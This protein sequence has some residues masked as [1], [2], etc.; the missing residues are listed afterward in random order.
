MGKCSF[1]I[2]VS[3][4]PEIL[5]VMYSWCH[6]PTDGTQCRVC[7]WRLLPPGI[8]LAAI[9]PEAVSR[10]V[11]ISA[12]SL[13]Q[14]HRLERKFRKVQSFHSI[15]LHALEQDIESIKFFNQYFEQSCCALSIAKVLPSGLNHGLL[16]R[17]SR[18]KK[19]D[20]VEFAVVLKYLYQE[21]TICI[22]SVNIV[23]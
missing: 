17:M 7:L 6:R 15:L 11:R 23:V 19:K 13:R 2:A 18:L 12:P 16:K 5:K 3:F 14:Q 21:V 1:F 20:P 10:L 4:M 22:Y 8:L 9:L